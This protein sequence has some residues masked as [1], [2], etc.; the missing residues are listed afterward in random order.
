MNRTDLTLRVRSLTRDS[1]GTVFKDTDIHNFLNEGIDR[2][3]QVITEFAKLGY[4]NESTDSPDMLP[5]MYHHL[6][7]LYST[8]RCFGQDERHYQAGNYMNEFESKLQELL[9]SIEVG[10]IEIIDPETGLPVESKNKAEY[11]HDNYFYRK[12]RLSL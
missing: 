6:L 1:S 7:A 4:L 5:V 8:S 3:K 12:G 9:T 10:D 11:V 2:V